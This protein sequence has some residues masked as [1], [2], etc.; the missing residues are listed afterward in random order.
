[1]I[2]VAAFFCELLTLNRLRPQ[3]IFRDGYVGLL[4]FGKK[5]EDV[6]L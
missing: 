3:G 5:E 6:N 1:M 2:F 4:T